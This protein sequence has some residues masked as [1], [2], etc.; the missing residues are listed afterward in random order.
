MF[1]LNFGRSV[2]IATSHSS[3]AHGVSDHQSP[4]LLHGP[5]NAKICRRAPSQA[6]KHRFAFFELND[7][8][9]RRPV[10]A[11]RRRRL[12]F[13]VAALVS[14]LRQHKALLPERDSARAYRAAPALH[15]VFSHR[16]LNSRKR[17]FQTFRI[18]RE[19]QGTNQVAA[20]A[21]LREPFAYKQIRTGK[22]GGCALEI[23][24]Q[25]FQKQFAI[26]TPER[27]VAASG[28]GELVLCF[29]SLSVRASA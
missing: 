8:R 23:E 29:A 18:G 21:L 2:R 15:T 12:L 10:N 26:S 7:R 1:R 22:E 20:S 27:E 28:Y 6:E 16:V 11:H 5:A 9:K 24:L 4:F 3:R 14:H 25:K 13:C 19:R 17:H